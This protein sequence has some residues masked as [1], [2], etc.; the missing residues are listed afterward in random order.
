MRE[1][2]LRE[3][4]EVLYIEG[5]FVEVRDNDT[6]EYYFVNTKL[7]EQEVRKKFKNHTMLRFIS[8]YNRNK[9]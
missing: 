7:S 9:R 8:Y 4:H 5:S 2:S 6:G 1:L 3:I